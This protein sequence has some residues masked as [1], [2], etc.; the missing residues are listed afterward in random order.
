[1]MLPAAGAVILDEE[2]NKDSRTTCRSSQS[3]EV[4]NQESRFM[5]DTDD[6][7]DDLS[8]SNR[9]IRSARTTRSKVRTIGGG[10]HKAALTNN[11]LEFGEIEEIAV[12]AQYEN[13]TAA[14]SNE[15]N[16]RDKRLLKALFEGYV[17]LML[18][19]KTKLFFLR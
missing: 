4:V 19:Y 1:M 18:Q 6:D 2:D 3:N 12:A 15:H 7:D 10:G 13:K 5:D 17:E 8:Y 11:D 14:V 9:G 16:N